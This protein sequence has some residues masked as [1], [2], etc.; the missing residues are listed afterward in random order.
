MSEKAKKPIFKRWWF[1][2]IVIVFIVAIA[3]QGGNDGTVY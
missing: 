2:L 3:S 1:W